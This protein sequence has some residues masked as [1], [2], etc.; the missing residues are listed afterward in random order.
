MKHLSKLAAF[1]LAASVLPAFAGD[2]PVKAR[3]PVAAPVASWTGFY[4]GLNAG[5]GW[6]DASSTNNPVDPASQ[7]FFSPSLGFG[8]TDFNTSF[9]QEGWI[10]GGQAGYNW[11][12]SSRGVVGIEADL[13]YADVKGAGSRRAFLNPDFFSNDFG[14]DSIGER[15]LQW[16]GTV[17]GRLGFLATPSLLLYG[18]GGLA[19]GET[20]SRGDVILNP[21]GPSLVFVSNGGFNFSCKTAGAGQTSACYTGSNAESKVGWTAGFG[22][23]WKF[24]PTWSAKLEYLHVELPGTSATLVS[25]SPPSTPGVNTIHRFNSQAY[26]FVRVGVNYQFGGP[27]VVAKY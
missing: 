27:A 16:F 2:M 14:F 10:A 8:P 5:Y 9:R 7:E 22:G 1:F 3:P 25:P 23:E 12:F 26:D 4:A 18:T 6:G 11:Q 17:R 24:S 15:R 19:Y 20:Q 13:Q 21:A